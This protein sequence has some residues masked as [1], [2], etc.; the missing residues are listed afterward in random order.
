MLGLEEQK[1]L[2][3]ASSAHSAVEE[4]LTAE[5]AEVAEEAQ[6][7]ELGQKL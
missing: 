2:F 3:S 1:K 6:E 5:D 4:R 7:H